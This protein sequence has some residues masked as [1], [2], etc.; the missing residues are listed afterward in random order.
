MIVVGV[1]GSGKTTLL[2]A[3]LNFHLGVKRDDKFR[4]ILVDDSKKDKTK[5]CTTKVTKYF[6]E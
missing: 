6:I 2:N 4:Y 5:S 1:T 3:I